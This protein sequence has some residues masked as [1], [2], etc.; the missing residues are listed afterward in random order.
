MSLTTYYPEKS[1]H[2]E[3]S[4]DQF[5]LYLVAKTIFTQVY[6]SSPPS[7][8]LIQTG[9]ILATYEYANGKVE[10]ALSSI[11]LCARMGYACRIHLSNPNT[12]LEG[13][14]FLQAE[15]EANT[16]WGIAICERYESSKSRS[17]ENLTRCIELFSVNLM[18][19]ISLLRQDSRMFKHNY[20]GRH[21]HQ[22]TI[23]NS[24]PASLQIPPRHQ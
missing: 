23:I 3:S 17:K 2:D 4:V 12:K 18:T 22:K 21:T 8:H 9:I 14:E 5:S 13:N 19:L 7:L 20:Q 16:W 11:G 10:N 24:N 6:S 1:G 15:E